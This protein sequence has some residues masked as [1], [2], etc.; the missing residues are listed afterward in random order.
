[1]A[2]PLHKTPTLVSKREY[3]LTL[4]GITAILVFIAV[5]VSL[6]LAQSGPPAKETYV[7]PSNTYSCTNTNVDGTWEKVCALKGPSPEAVTVPPTAT[8]TE[9][10]ITES[11]I[12]TTEKVN[13]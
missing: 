10:A 11:S 12:Q 13:P 3:V 9:T 2:N 1:M 5:M 4:T 7:F 6:T 8:I